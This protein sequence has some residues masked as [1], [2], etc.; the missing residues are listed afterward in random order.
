MLDSTPAM[1]TVTRLSM[2]VKPRARE[3]TVDAGMASLRRSTSGIARDGGVGRARTHAAED[4]DDVAYRAAARIGERQRSARRARAV[5]RVEHD[6]R[7]VAA[8]RDALGSREDD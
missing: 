3:R 1:A 6:R 4:V 8:D 7:D 5:Q 2:S